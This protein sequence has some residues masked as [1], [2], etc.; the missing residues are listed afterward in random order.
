LI[1]GRMARR[2]ARRHGNRSFRSLFPP[3]GQ[4]LRHAGENLFS[5]LTGSSSGQDVPGSARRASAEEDELPAGDDTFIL[6]IL[7]HPA[8]LMVTGLVIVTLI[9]IRSLIGSGRLVGGALLPAPDTIGALWQTYTE[10]WHGVGLGSDT[11]A[12][13]YLGVI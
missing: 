12:P 6:R 2:R 4:Q 9:A 1:K 13:P 10:S 3:R 8:V 5:M 11:D 7:T